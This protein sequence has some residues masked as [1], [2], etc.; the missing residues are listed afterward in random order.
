MHPAYSVIIFTTVSGAGFG[1]LIWLAFSLLFL[2]VI[3]LQPLPGLIA[4][5]LAF[6]LIS[7]GLASSTL[8]LGRPERAWRAF[9]QWR[10]SWLSREGVVAVASYPVGWAF[11]SALDAEA[12]VAVDRRT[13][14]AV[15]LAGAAHALLHRHDLRLASDGPCVVPAIG[16]SGLHRPRPRHRR[17]FGAAARRLDGGRGALA[18][19]RGR[20]VAGR[21]RIGA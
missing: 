10:T 8:H 20:V 12:D 18:C 9:S 14:L 7:I 1:L 2:E 19:G 11:C 16:L 3:P 15:D 4:F 5:G 6:V 21:D 17:R 13:R